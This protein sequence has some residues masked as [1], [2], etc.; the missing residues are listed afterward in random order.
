MYA[1]MLC[2]LLPP[3]LHAMIS[4]HDKV[5][6]RATRT[7]IRRTRAASAGTASA[8][9]LRRFSL[10][11]RGVARAAGQRARASVA[12]RS[13]APC[14]H[15]G[16]HKRARNHH[17]HLC[18][19]RILRQLVPLRECSG[20]T[21]ALGLYRLV[22]CPRRARLSSCREIHGLAGGC[23]GDVVDAGRPRS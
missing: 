7:M 14:L 6:I 17:H 21:P 5:T 20:A 1:L 12:A 19:V 3:H 15:S 11:A 10:R 2:L 22:V 8:S 9:C 18:P 23:A 13:S 16:L 4:D